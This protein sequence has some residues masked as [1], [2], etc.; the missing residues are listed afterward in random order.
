MGAIICDVTL[1]NVDLENAGDPNNVTGTKLTKKLERTAKLR[2]LTPSR[3]TKLREHTDYGLSAH[4]QKTVAPTS[5]SSTNKE[6][7]LQPTFLLF[8]Y[9]QSFLAS[10]RL[11]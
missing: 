8:G 6:W 7:R 1:T 5:V 3:S 9:R 11:I 10:G 2:L 4:H